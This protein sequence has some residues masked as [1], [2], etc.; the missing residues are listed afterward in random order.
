MDRTI[1]RKANPV[2]VKNFDKPQ[3]ITDKNSNHV[4]YLNNLKFSR[5]DMTD[6]FRMLHPTIA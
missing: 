5:V 4:D 3:S 6:I 1:R 2:R